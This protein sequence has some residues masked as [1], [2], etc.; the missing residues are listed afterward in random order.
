MRVGLGTNGIGITDEVAV[1]LK[2]CGAGSVA[3]S[4]DSC[5]PEIHDEFRGMP[6]AWAGAIAGI[7]ASLMNGLRVQF[8]T[9]VTQENFDAIG[10]I[11]ALG[12]SWG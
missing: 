1:R 11:L 8:N 2:E 7:K 6:G 9:T 10:N 3:I 4:L 5:T 12:R